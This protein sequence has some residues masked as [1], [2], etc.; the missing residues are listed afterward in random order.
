MTWFAVYVSLV[1]I[2]GKN[3][4]HGAMTLKKKKELE[5]E[6]VLGEVALGILQV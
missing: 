1:L 2:R 4:H 6:H 3:G 5:E